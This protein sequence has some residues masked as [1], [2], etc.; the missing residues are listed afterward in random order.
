[1]LDSS[2]GV[3]VSTDEVCVLYCRAACCEPARSD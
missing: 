3:V 2:V 1:L